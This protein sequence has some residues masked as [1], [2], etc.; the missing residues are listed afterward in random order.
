MNEPYGDKNGEIP[1]TQLTGDDLIASIEENSKIVQ[2]G[3]ETPYD[4]SWFFSYW[5]LDKLSTY[6]LPFIPELTTV[7]NYDAMTLSLNATH[8]GKQQDYDVHSLYP[9]GM[10]AATVSGIQGDARPFYL[11]KGSYS[12][13][14][15][16]TGAVAHTDNDRTWDALYYGLQSVL[17]S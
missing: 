9:L 3:E 16:F 4:Q 5:P 14:S 11:T 17:R 6:F 1:S 15:R 2:G 7:G 10:A 12:G 13:I 8:A